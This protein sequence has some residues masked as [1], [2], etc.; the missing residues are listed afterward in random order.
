MKN[1]SC[2]I[3]GKNLEVK[4]NGVT[5]IGYEDYFKTVVKQPGMDP[6]AQAL[7]KLEQ[8]W[9][10]KLVAARKEEAEKAYKQGF[11][12]GQKLSKANAEQHLENFK[13]TMKDA[14]SRIQG[15]IHEVK[16]GITD[17][18]FDLA[19]KVMEIPVESD[20]LR[21]KVAQELDGLLQ[22]L[23][24]TSR[25]RLQVSTEDYEHIFSMIQETHHSDKLSI[26]MLDDL[27]PGE[28]QLDTDQEKVVK[29]FREI[30]K[31]YRQQL[32]SNDWGKE[33]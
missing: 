23:D 25:I 28:Y 24:I 11:N 27:N 5:R 16:P 1:Q 32:L 4:A 12:D 13:K 15:L 31:D 33:Q 8:E 26:Q 22:Q 10:E 18:I 14:D 3:S 9:T 21:M 2:I 19:E 20:M 7:A 30:L 29:D 6:Q 17:L